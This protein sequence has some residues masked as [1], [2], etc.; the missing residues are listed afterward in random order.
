MKE[1]K[2]NKLALLWKRLQRIDAYVGWIS[3]KLGTLLGVLENLRKYEKHKPAK[4]LEIPKYG[5]SRG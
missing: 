5:V 1:G 4:T 3:G 2:L